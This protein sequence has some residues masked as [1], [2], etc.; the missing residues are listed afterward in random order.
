[1]PKSPKALPRGANLMDEVANDPCQC[2]CTVLFPISLGN[3]G[4]KLGSPVFSWWESL[5]E[6]LQ[7]IPR[8]VTPCLHCRAEAPEH[9][10]LRVRVSPALA[11][12]G[13]FMGLD[14]LLPFQK[15]FGA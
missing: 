3:V 6:V 2:Y 13:T 15:E 8:G 5:L 11:L 10:S 7:G 4:A 12:M 1:M 14:T 9:Q